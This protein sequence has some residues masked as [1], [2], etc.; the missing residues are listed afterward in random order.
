MPG[1]NSVAVRVKL[2]DSAAEAAVVSNITVF[3]DRHGC[4]WLT[5]VQAVDATV[6]LS[7]RFSGANERGDTV[8]MGHGF[9]VTAQLRRIAHSGNAIDYSATRG[10]SAAIDDRQTARMSSGDAT[11][12]LQVSGAPFLGD[13]GLSTLVMTLD[14]SA[15]T[16]RFAAEPPVRAVW[17]EPGQPD[18]D[19]RAVLG[20]LTLRD[21]PADPAA[22]IIDG[23]ADVPAM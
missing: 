13:D 11:Q 3:D 7:Y 12:T 5:E 21:R 19:A 2:P 23:Q 18:P 10:G 17:T 15:C 1:A 9:D 4:G 6:R 22:A 20:M 8:S 14:L 16:Y